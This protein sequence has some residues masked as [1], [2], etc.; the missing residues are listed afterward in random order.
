VWQVET[1]DGSLVSLEYVSVFVPPDRAH[2]TLTDI[3]ARQRLE[4]E[5]DES[6][7][8]LRLAF[9]ASP[10][11]FLVILL[12]NDAGDAAPSFVVEQANDAARVLLPDLT[13]G[14]VVTRGDPLH[15]HIA[16]V[17]PAALAA[18]GPV[19]GRREVAFPSG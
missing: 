18:A 19:H 3:T 5:R 11:G 2:T 13:V 6:T 1:A 9:D 16:S 12:Q 14:A 15:P 17:V 7:F 10:D 8:L 4:R